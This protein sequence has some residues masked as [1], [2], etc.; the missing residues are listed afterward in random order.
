MKRNSLTRLGVGL[1]ILVATL[2]AASCADSVAD[3]GILTAD[4]PLH[5]EDHID[6]A[7]IEGSELPEIADN[8]LEPIEWRF[9][10]P[11]PEWRPT[12][13]AESQP[14]RLTQLKDAL[15]LDITA[16]NYRT[17][18]AGPHVHDGFI[19]IDVP[20]LSPED[21]GYVSVRARAQP[22]AWLGLGLQFNLTDR[23]DPSESPASGYSPIGG[24][25]FRSD[26][27]RTPLIRDGLEHTYL[28]PTCLR[29]EGQDC[30]QPWKQ[31]GLR[32]AAGSQPGSVPASIDILSVSLIPEQAAYA[33]ANVGIIS[34]LFGSIKQRALYTHA[35][36]RLEYRVRVPDGGRFDVGL[37][38]VRDDAPVHF[39][40]TAQPLAGEAV[41]LLEETYSD[42][43]RGAQRSVDLAR[44][45]GETVRLV[46]SATSDRVGTL[47]LWIAPMLSGSRNTH[48]PNIILYVIDSAGADFMSAYG[49]NRRTTPYLERLAAEG[50][51]FEHAYSNSTYTHASTRSFVTSLHDSVLGADGGS[52]PEEAITM[53]QHMRAGGYQTALLSSNSN[54][55]SATDRGVDTYRDTFSGVNSASSVELHRDFWNWR[56]AS[57]GEPY[58]VHFQTTDVHAP[59]HPPAPF[60]GLFIS[61]ELRETYY[62]WSRQLRSARSAGFALRSGP[63]YDDAGVDRVAHA[64]AEQGL[65]DETMD[66]NDYQIGRLV[67]RL[68]AA[69]EWE[70]TLL[71]VAS[72]HGYPG[73]SPRRLDPMPPAG[74]KA[75]LRPHDTR[76][77]LIFVW[78]EHIAPGQRF[79]DPV[80]MIDLLPTILDLAGLPEPEIMQGQS[81]AP[82]L[83]GKDEWEPRPVI[84]D[85]FYRDPVSGQ[86]F[87]WIEVIDGRWAASLQ[88]NP[89]PEMTEHPRFE[90]RTA[91]LLL[92][93]LWN[94][95][96][97]LH[98]LHEERRDLVNEY[99]TF[100]EAEW[101]KHQRL[102]KQFT[103]GEESPFTPEQLETLRAL[104]YI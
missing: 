73:A 66:H 43:E 80:S 7:T 22:G 78:P 36:A 17:S 23:S 31:V 41:I 42:S 53:A 100:L 56:N 30:D 72:D 37:G 89:N 24:W 49:Y 57:P 1:G 33:D 3:S 102:A 9:D 12:G 82:L 6:Q 87:G 45:E 26:G 96:M 90:G 4:L 54:A 59:F 40:I 46:L 68:K 20:D 97:C 52:L 63:Y 15:R 92:Y 38:V 14:V 81:L 25:P 94:D 67:E 34:R 61:P 95:P 101:K 65:Y 21:W 88:I 28:L 62:E 99:T 93:D 76:V 18:E 19:Y 71:I 51:I 91:A 103:P 10:E 84:F 69:G 11:Q 44:F 98:S 104:G 48:K 35:P 86:L 16:A 70:H 29:E 74:Q 8:L 75:L 85:E 77:P 47:A 39:A 32:I 58:W 2:L 27:G 50:A 5:L 83:L 13:Y 64:H 79:A 55:G 60:A